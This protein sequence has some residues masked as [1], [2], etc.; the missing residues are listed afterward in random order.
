VRLVVFYIVRFTTLYL[1]ADFHKTFKNIMA[2]H[3]PDQMFF[4]HVT[5]V[6]VCPE[7]YILF[8]WFHFYPDFRT[9]KQRQPPSSKVRFY[10]IHISITMRTCTLFDSQRKNCPGY[11]L[12]GWRHMRPH[13]LISNFIDHTCYSYYDIYCMHHLLVLIMHSLRRVLLF[14]SNRWRVDCQ[15]SSW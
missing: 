14:L 10:F 2:S 3:R 9:Q 5:S 11:S 6:V 4:A 1:F 15:S 8:P 12:R 7:P 13:P